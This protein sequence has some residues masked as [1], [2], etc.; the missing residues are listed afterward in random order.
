MDLDL[1]MKMIGFSS[2]WR[3]GGFVVERVRN[4]VDG[5]VHVHLRVDERRIAKCPDCGGRAGVNRV[6]ENTARDLPVLEKRTIIHYP[7]VQVR[8]CAC[9]TYRTVRPAEIDG[10]RRATTRMMTMT[11]FL[12]LHMPLD[13]VS[14]V[15]GIG[16]AT[17]YRWDRAVLERVLPEPDLDNLRVLLIDEKSVRKRHGYV[18]L[19]MNG[20]T[21][22][23]LFMAEGKKKATLAAF[24]EMLSEEQKARIKAVCIDRA[25]AYREAVAEAVPHAEIVYDK[26]HVMRNLNQAVDEVRREEYR[27]ASEEDRAFI[28]GQRYN[29]LRHEENLPLWSVQSLKRLREANENLNLTYMLKESFGLVWC[30]RQTKRARDTL[31]SWI[32]WVEQTTIEPL[33]KF[34][35]GV[36]RDAD[37]IVSYCRHR[38]TNGPLEG[39]NNLVARVMHKACGIRNTDYLFLKL[40]QISL[41]SVLQN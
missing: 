10:R 37:Q 26:F 39:F 14:E 18:T 25:G 24:F 21:G 20:D 6:E 1:R 30:Y 11:H 38:I 35:C 12:C 16:S 28:K 4:E 2:L 40:R 41:R 17:A 9:C 8:C 31:E 19:V 36:R 27:N 29:L 13:A 32:G 34:A 23:L 3:F 15:L 7:A 22:E 33:L 5:D